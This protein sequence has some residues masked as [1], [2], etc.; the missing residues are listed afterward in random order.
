MT[1]QE[2]YQKIE[3]IY[4][5][6]NG[7]KFISHLVRAF[8]PVN[9]AMFML[10]IETD[11]ARTMKCCI[12][13]EQTYNKEDLLKHFIG[14]KEIFMKKFKLMTKQALGDEEAKPDAE[15]M[16]F[17][18]EAL[19][20]KRNLSVI[21]LESDKVFS[22]IA[23]Q[24]FAN[25][26]MTKLMMN[27]GHINWVLRDVRNKTIVKHIESKGHDVSQKEKKVIDKATRDGRAKFSLSDNEA[28]LKLKEKMK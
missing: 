6:D 26:V 18:E 19:K 9:K 3:K 2:I 12:T 25:F 13:G 27:D 28:L 4:S 22:Q 1:E 10:G 23:W 21:S 11:K 24:Q 8:F 15:L 7:K 5:T 14:D 16:Q 17:D 20:L